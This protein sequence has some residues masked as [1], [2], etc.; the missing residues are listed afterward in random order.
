MLRYVT[1]GDR[2]VDP[3]RGGHFR[4]L[5][6]AGEAPLVRGVGGVQYGLAFVR[7]RGAVPMCTEYGVCSAIPEC[8]CS[9][10]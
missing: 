2:L 10:L 4:C 8:R 9:W 7:H 1:F 3:R 6:V 5:G